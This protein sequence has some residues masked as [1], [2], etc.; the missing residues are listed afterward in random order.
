M[1]YKYLITLL[2]IVSVCLSINVIAATD[3]NLTFDDNLSNQ[4]III[5]EY[6]DD[7]SSSLN[8]LSYSNDDNYISNSNQNELS[9]D[10]SYYEINV[11]TDDGTVGDYEEGTDP[12]YSAVNK[13]NENE[14]IQNVTLNIANGRYQ[15]FPT[16]MF[17]LN[18]VKNMV[19]N[20]DGNEVIIE[21]LMPE[22]ELNRYFGF[23]HSANVIFNNII[24]DMSSLE[25]GDFAGACSEL[26]VTYNECTFIGGSNSL[27]GNIADTRYINCAF[28]NFTSDYLF[29]VLSKFAYFENCVFSNLDA[30][31]LSKTATKSAYDQGKYNYTF[32][33]VWFGNNQIPTYITSYPA[34][35]NT[36][37][38]TLPID[39]YALFTVFE[40]YLGDNQYEIVGKL[41]W[42]GTDS[43]EG[44]ENFPPMTVTLTSTTGEIQNVTLVNGT[45]K[46]IYT[47]ESSEHKVT[48]KLDSE[49]Q[50]L[51][52]TNIALNLNA[53]T[54][55]F[56][57]NQ[58][59]VVNL[60]KP[61]TGIVTVTVN[62]KDY[63]ITI[64]NSDSIAVPIDETLNVGTHDVNVTFIDEE[65][66]IHGFNTT[67]ITISTVKDYTFNVSAISNVKVG[68]TK[69]LVITLPNDA[70]GNLTVYLGTS[71]FTEIINGNTTTINITGFV[72]GQ[73]TITITYSGNDK[74]EPNTKNITV[75][76]VQETKI[77]APNV[78]T[79]Y[80]VAKN[81][82]ITLK[83]A[84]N[85]ILVNK[86][87]TVK[88][89][90]I[91]KTLTTNT[92][93]QASIA[94]ASL[95]PKTYT[96]TISFA[97]DDQYV[98]STAT[99][100]VVVAKAKPKLTA[101]KTTFKVKTKTKKYSIILKDNKGKAIK[102]AKVTLKVK[103]KTYKAT[104]NAKGK[105]T[106]KITKLTKKG[107]STATI[108]FAGNKYF[109][110]ISKKAK[111]IVK[112]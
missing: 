86:K 65:N 31:R 30:I 68:D 75:A 59:I 29:D 24:F 105:A 55:N 96:A 83:D 5:D 47:S 41:T 94:I 78:S 111:I 61:V 1:K 60:S 28:Y 42:N 44:M 57:E 11:T 16:E 87:V 58:N 21:P 51:T 103:G 98:K 54:I 34:N 108:K 100:K 50:N 33:G 95:V 66:H 39:K 9:E 77:T 64:D 19:V 46:A 92:K 99:A 69:Q 14:N 12:L 52:F 63:P 37:G 72:I 76:A 90:L 88:V 101:K 7:I 73:N 26:P 104:T 10:N 3:V 36:P 82:V 8:E 32:N 80:N 91:T 35:V 2:L 89:G 15:M 84:N 97:G 71:N 25:E 20:G 62:G 53:P 27:F 106:F 79:T 112:K 93:G 6:D 74:Y 4:E 107:T 40:K 49:E 67:T 45:F 48:A 43:S 23:E 102:K 17:Y 13:I 81:L 56:G 70:T 109:K 38:F 110:S 22:M 85:Q 18:N